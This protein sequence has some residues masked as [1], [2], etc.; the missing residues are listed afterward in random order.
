[1]SGITCLL[2]WKEAHFLVQITLYK[3][4]GPGQN[5]RVLIIINFVT[6]YYISVEDNISVNASAHSQM[7]IIRLKDGRK[8]E[9]ICQNSH[10]YP[11]HNVYRIIYKVDSIQISL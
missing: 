2:N 6:P 9:N 8:Q 3:A 7:S 4:K 5:L 1:M 10:L 11:L